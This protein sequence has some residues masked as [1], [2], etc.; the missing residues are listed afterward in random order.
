MTDKEHIR[1]RADAISERLGNEEY[2]R[3]MLSISRDLENKGVKIS[4][5]YDLDL[6][7]RVELLRLLGG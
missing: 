4:E 1:V 5:F 7:E 6:D 3:R 2:D